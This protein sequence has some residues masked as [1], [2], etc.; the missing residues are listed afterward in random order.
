MIVSDQSKLMK[1]LSDLKSMASSDGAYVRATIYNYAQEY[2]ARDYGIDPDNLSYLSKEDFIT[3]MF[4]FSI[5][6]HNIFDIRYR[7]TSR[8]NSSIEIEPSVE[9]ELGVYVAKSSDN[10]T[11]ITPEVMEIFYSLPIVHWN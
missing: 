8:S 7:I 9:I 4:D 6:F 5:A 11:N 10:T 3:K 1:L 2:I